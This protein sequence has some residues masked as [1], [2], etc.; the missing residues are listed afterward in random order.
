MERPKEMTFLHTAVEE[1]DFFSENR[2]RNTVARAADGDDALDHSNSRVNIG[3]NL[4]TTNSGDGWKGVEEK[5][6]PSDEII[7]QGELNRLS[8]ENR[9]LRSM[10]D[11]V[12]ENYSALYSQLLQVMQHQ[13]VP[14]NRIEERK[15]KKSEMA[16][17]TTISAKQLMDPGRISMRETNEQHYRTSDADK[18]LP[19]LSNSIDE[20]GAI[21]FTKRP[22]SHDDGPSDGASPSW[23][24]NMNQKQNQERIP[25]QM[26]EY[27][28]RKARVSVR[29][30]SDAPMIS[31][32]CQWRKYGQK[33]AKGNPC[34]RAY[35]RC[36]MAI[37][38]PVRKQVQRC[39]DDKTILITTYE[40]NH[41]HPLPP[42]ATTMAKT[43]SAAAT[44]L[45][46]GS[47]TSKD[48]LVTSPFCNPF[49]P[50]TSTMATLSA[51]APF[52]TITLDLTQPPTAPLHQSQHFPLSMC[53]PPR[54]PGSSSTQFAQLQ[55]Q[56][57]VLAETVTAAIASDPNFTA[58]L[59]VAI[60]SI[61]AAPR[62]GNTAGNSGSPPRTQSCTTFSTN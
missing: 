26:L 11:Q 22:I 9:Q 57:S 3:L 54:H 48:S 45:L 10:L 58:A 39:A 21:A 19:T 49:S 18:Q 34:P 33:M 15:E 60:S 8:D 2:L 46:S 62:T 25:D 61:M 37:G 7:L 14:E 28:C 42:A 29:A 13:G 47:T 56:P 35:F 55:R 5:E 30:R 20:R 32:G 40:G 53:L 50:Y 36:T 41:N 6:K 16:A 27:P 52:P 1:V 4:L 51:S 31:D 17:P 38:C 24:S 43:T 12:T 23:G 59:A 44:M